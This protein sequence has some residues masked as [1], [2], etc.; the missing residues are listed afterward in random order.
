MEHASGHHEKAKAAGCD[1]GGGADR[2]DDDAAC[3]DPGACC[4]GVPV[5]PLASDDHRVPNGYEATRAGQACTGAGPAGPDRPPR[6][7]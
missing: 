6:V 2:A 3:C 4:T 7:V 5:L 1:G